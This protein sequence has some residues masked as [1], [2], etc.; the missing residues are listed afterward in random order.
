MPE[1]SNH[2]GGVGPISINNASGKETITATLEGT[3]AFDS[4]SRRYSMLGRWHCPLSKAFPP[5][6]FGLVRSLRGSE[7][8]PDAKRSSMNGIFDGYCVVTTMSLDAK[9]DSSYRDRLVFEKRIKLE[10]KSNKKGVGNTNRGILEVSGSGANKFG[11]FVIHGMAKPY[12]S[13][14]KN[15]NILY[16]VVLQKRYLPNTAL[17]S[18]Q[19]NTDL[20]NTPLTNTPQNTATVA[21]AAAASHVHKKIRPTRSNIIHGNGTIVRKKFGNGTYCEG[22]V[23]GYDPVQKYYTIRYIDGNHDVFDEADMKRYYKHLQRYSY[24]PYPPKALAVREV[25]HKLLH[26]KCVDNSILTRIK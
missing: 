15:S 5:Q 10:F 8:G 6:K 14:E 4:K 26:S 11:P 16:T 3:I 9:G 24:A 19:Q 12:T 22:E 2:K 1:V 13:C 18:K 20:P 7:E 17:P 25:R 21:A 23:A